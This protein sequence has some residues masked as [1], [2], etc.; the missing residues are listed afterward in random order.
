MIGSTE[1][2]RGL[3]PQH[4]VRGIYDYIATDRDAAIRSW[5]ELRP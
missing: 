4:I 3:T 2:A 1:M 5:K